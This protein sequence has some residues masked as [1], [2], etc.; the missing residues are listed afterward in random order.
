MIQEVAYASL[1][2]STARA[3]HRKAAEHYR[4]VDLILH[5]QHIERARDASAARAYEQAATEQLSLFR[6]DRTRELIE[7]GIA[8][9]TTADDRVALKLLDGRTLHDQGER[10][11]VPPC[12]TA[13][14][15]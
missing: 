14:R 3:L 9:A 13:T 15:A 7:R 4:D 8:I 11:A 2:H 10:L 1:L 12:L 5:A 6:Y